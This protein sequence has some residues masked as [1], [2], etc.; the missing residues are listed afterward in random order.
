MSMACPRTGYLR[1]GAQE[2][3]GLGGHDEVVLVQAAD[4]VRPPLDGDTPPFS[5]DQGMMVFLVSDGAD[6]VG[7]SK[8]LPKIR[9][10]ENTL[11]ALLAVDRANLPIGDLRQVPGNLGI[12]EA[13]L[14]TPAGDTF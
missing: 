12:R 7:E 4:L 10:L 14:T 11:Q 6:L 5:D 8:R 13:G 2:G 9:E 1:Y 3:V